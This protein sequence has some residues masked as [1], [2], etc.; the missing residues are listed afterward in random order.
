MT[1]THRKPGTT[2]EVTAQLMELRQTRVLMGVIVGA[3]LAVAG[4]LLQSLLR[5][6]LASPDLLT[7]DPPSTRHISTVERSMQPQTLPHPKGY[8]ELPLTVPAPL[9]RR[10][11]RFM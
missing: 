2:P 10:V 11:S 4:V 6:P 1:E 3:A 5:N 7:T 9:T 8:L